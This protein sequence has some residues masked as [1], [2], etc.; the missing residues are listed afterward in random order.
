MRKTCGSM[1]LRAR[2]ASRSLQ[3]LLTSPQ[4][5]G[6]ERVLLAEILRS[7]EKKFP[8]CATTKYALHK[9]ACCEAWLHNLL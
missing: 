2:A 5:H 4:V 9:G 3:V 6:F 1:T 8:R 7:P